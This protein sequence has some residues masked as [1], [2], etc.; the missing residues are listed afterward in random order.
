VARLVSY[1]VEKGKSFSELSL[2]EY[3]RFSPLF[4]E[5][6][7]SITVAS[8]IAARCVTGGTAP[9]QVA[10]ALAAAKKTIKKGES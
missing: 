6:V 5:D 1:A 7:Y 8:S 4:S 10:L 9:K 2:T 3:K